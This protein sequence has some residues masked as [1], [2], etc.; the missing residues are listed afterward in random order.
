MPPMIV[1]PRAPPRPKYFQRALRRKRCLPA[2]ASDKRC[3][4]HVPSPR[5]RDD[6]SAIARARED[7]AGAAG[8][9][10]ISSDA[11]IST[12]PRR[13][14][15][16]GAPRAEASSAVGR[17]RTAVEARQVDRVQA[18]VVPLRVRR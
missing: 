17:N 14:L 10:A 2:V 5:S 4:R 13:I 18:G 8:P 6:T 3:A 7:G 1:K 15:C 16:G 9:T 12:R 11:D